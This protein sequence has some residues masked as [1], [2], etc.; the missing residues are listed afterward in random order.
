MK[1]GVKFTEEVY[2]SICMY[3]S[4]QFFEKEKVIA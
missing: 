4:L 3:T 2:S 1:K